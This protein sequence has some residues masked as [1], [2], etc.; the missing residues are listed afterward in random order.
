MRYYIM[1]VVRTL[2]VLA[3]LVGCTLAGWRAALEYEWRMNHPDGREVDCYAFKNT[4]ERVTTVTTEYRDVT[5]IITHL[6]CGAWDGSTV[7][8]NLNNLSVKRTY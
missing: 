1:L 2:V 4:G 3:V 5:T 6:T 7:T 8:V